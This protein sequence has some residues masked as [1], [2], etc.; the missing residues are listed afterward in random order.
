MEC[1]QSDDMWAAECHDEKR[2]HGNCH[3]CVASICVVLD[4]SVGRN[5]EFATC[6]CMCTQ[7]GMSSL[8]PTDGW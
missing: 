3:E 7:Q 6:T 5:A 1:L 4:T 8:K 2:A